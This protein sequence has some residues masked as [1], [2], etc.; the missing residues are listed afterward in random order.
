MR[1]RKR[2]VSLSR[3][4]LPQAPELNA[5]L[6]PARTYGRPA[7][8]LRDANLSL[9]EKR[10]ILSSWASDACSVE[11]DPRLRR[12]AGLREPVTFEEVMEALR[13]LDGLA[14]GGSRADVAPPAP[15]IRPA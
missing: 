6:Q 12:P 8:V 2:F 15:E 13:Q 1:R 7:A 5:L 9:D 10:A 14:Q 11:S 4:S 3:R